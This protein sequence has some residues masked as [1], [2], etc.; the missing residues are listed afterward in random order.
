M[1][2]PNGTPKGLQQV[3]EERGFNV[4][5][6]RVKCSPVCPFESHGCCM[7]RLLSQQDDFVNQISMLETVITD[8]ASGKT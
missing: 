2:L 3:L 4:K 1:T 7:A 8:A 6:L 5:G